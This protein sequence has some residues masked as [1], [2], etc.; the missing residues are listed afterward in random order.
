MQIS[1]ILAALAV[2]I[3]CIFGSVSLCYDLFDQLA[4]TVIYCYEFVRIA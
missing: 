3:N 1:L 4:E 2:K